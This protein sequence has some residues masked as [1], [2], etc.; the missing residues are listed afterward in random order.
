MRPAVSSEPVHR[1]GPSVGGLEDL[2]DEVMRKRV[3]SAGIECFTNV[4]SL[5]DL[6][7]LRFWPKG[8]RA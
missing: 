5:S 7:N 8:S 6:P 3:G 4:L 1:C 2:P